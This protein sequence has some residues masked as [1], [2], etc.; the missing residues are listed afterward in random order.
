MDAQ[1]ELIVDARGAGTRSAVAV[2]GGKITATASGD[3]DVDALLVRLRGKDTTVRQYDGVLAPL[4]I[5]THNHLALASR[6]KLGVPMRDV[7][8]IEDVLDRIRARAAVTPPGSWVITA[9]DWHEMQ[10]RERRL[11]TA[12]ELDAAAPNHPVLVQ[13]GGH[14]AVLNTAG[15]AAAGITATSG[16]VPDG[17]VA[18]AVDG[19]PTGL[20]QDG[21]FTA[22]QPLL[23]K[24]SQ[25]EL[26]RAI[27]ATSRE[28][29]AVGVGTVRDPAVSVE[30]WQAMQAARSAGRLHVRTFSMIFSPAA[31][32]D[33]AGSMDAYLD[34]LE[35][36]GLHPDTG[37]DMLRL[38]GIKL[39]LDGGVEAGALRA[40]YADRPDFSGT[41]LMTPD[42]LTDALGAC[43]R[44]GWPVGTH[45]TGDAAIDVFLDAVQRN[46]DLGVQHRQGRLV[47]E[48]GALID[49]EQIA[50]AKAL[51]VH[52]TAQQ[53]LRDG[54]VAPFTQAW[55]PERVAAMFPWR[56]LLDTRVPVSAGTDHPIGPLNPLAG[57]VWMTTRKTSL[58]TL[59]P[60]HACTRIEALDLYTSAGAKLLEH[61][62]TGK[63]A[64]GSPADFGVYPV[65]LRH[66]TD[67]ELL[68]RHPTATVLAGAE[69]RHDVA[70]EPP[71]GK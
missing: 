58:G 11:P 10:L 3:E 30:D 14:N 32:I 41:L 61:D 35:A 28:Y 36:Q 62:L 5:D 59:G 31:L 65:D 17:H 70:I 21:A 46:V 71:Q 44:R 48:H 39:I 4:F 69:P 60:E 34:D 54:L 51:D 52:I 57:I 64:V 56:E 13:R 42:A 50:R 2:R 47:L 53:A 67:E 55:G 9:A 68:H 12:V 8:T 7:V 33:A 40:P 16:D 18:R 22:I 6:N 1:A 23:P 49:A 66:A 37:D 38:W 25:Q 29:R 26:V 43:V 45:A 19:T 15:L 24:V 20:V 27:E 63:I